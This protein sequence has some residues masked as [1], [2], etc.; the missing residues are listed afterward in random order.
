MRG[1]EEVAQ[2]AGAE[3]AEDVSGIVDCGFGIGDLGGRQE[4][5]QGTGGAET[6]AEEE[7]GDKEE[8]GEHFFAK[9]SEAERG[10]RIRG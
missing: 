2:G 8:E 10:S 1:G 5:T 6:G 7:E 9:R 4:I 3:E